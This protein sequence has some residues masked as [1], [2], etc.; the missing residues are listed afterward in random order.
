MSEVSLRIWEL[1]SSTINVLWDSI[2]QIMKML[3]LV[4]NERAMNHTTS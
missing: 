3:A 4:Q 2:M 1:F